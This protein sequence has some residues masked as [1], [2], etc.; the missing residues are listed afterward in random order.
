M[1]KVVVFLFLYKRSP[2]AFISEDLS[3]Y[4][5]AEPSTKNSNY[6]LCTFVSILINA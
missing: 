3:G 5:K 2:N 6:C 1:E 4:A